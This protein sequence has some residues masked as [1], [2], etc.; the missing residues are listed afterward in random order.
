MV[1]SVSSHSAFAESE[2][3]LDPVRYPGS[4][5]RHSGIAYSRA[6][7]LIVAPVS[8][9]VSACGYFKP[10]FGTEPCTCAYGVPAVLV[11]TKGWFAER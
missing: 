4:V 9:S 10:R 11:T 2:L 1:V 7:D 3:G 8:T 5:H 6:A